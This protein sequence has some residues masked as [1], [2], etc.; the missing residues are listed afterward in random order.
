MPYAQHGTK[1]ATT[2]ASGQHLPAQQGSQHYKMPF[3]FH[4]FGKNGS[5]IIAPMNTSAIVLY[6]VI[7]PLDS[8]V[9]IVIICITNDND[10]INKHASIK[11]IINI[12]K[13]PNE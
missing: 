11:E 1:N 2:V 5:G 3:K 4:I 6:V 13:L 8:N 7:I 9:N 10:V 12:I